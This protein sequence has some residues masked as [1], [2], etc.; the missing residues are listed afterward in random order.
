MSGVFFYKEFNDFDLGDSNSPLRKKFDVIIKDLEE[1]KHTSLGDIK[2]I[3][4]DGGIKYLRAKL[5]DSDRLLFTSIRYNDKDVFVILEVILNHDYHKSKF[6]TSKEKIKN[7]KIIDQSSK[8]VSDTPE[9]KDTPQVCWLDKFITLSTTQEDIV[10]NKDLPLIISGAAGS[11]KTSVALE[12]LRK[13]EEKFK[14]GRI[15]YITQ[16]ENL[17]KKSKELYEYEYYDEAAGELKLG[18][19]NRI[20]FLSVH[21]LLKRRIKNIEGKKPIYRSKFFLW[22]NEACNRDKFKEYKKDGDKVLEEF[23]AV[24]GGRRLG[25]EEYKELGNRQ[26]IFPQGERDNIYGLFEKYKEFIEKDLEY[27]D[28]N[29]IAH[30]CT[31]EGIYDAVV[32]DEVQ[33]LTISIL[34]LILKSLKGESK[35]NFLLCGDVNQVIHPSFFSIS[36]L[37]SFLYDNTDKNIA[38]EVCVLEKNYRNSKQVIELANRILHLKNYCFAP[39]DKMTANEKEAFFMKSDTRNTGN[40]SF[41]ADNKK[42]K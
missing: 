41:I 20:D 10:E 35:G 21:E 33:D 24:I 19:P 3:T 18:V 28:P 36:R 22:F 30:E 32:V 37:K 26:A 42:G 39:E 12:K 8:E 27:Y 23:T 13:I 9:I 16:S 34:N 25:K 11:G 4:G 7:I 15:L 2:L 29:L 38:G 17:I 1:S 5:N 40:V 14:G 6:L 31:E